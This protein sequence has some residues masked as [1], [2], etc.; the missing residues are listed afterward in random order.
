MRCPRLLVCCCLPPQPPSGLHGYVRFATW[1]VRWGWLP[2]PPRPLLLRAGCG[3]A[4]LLP[5]RRAPTTDPAGCWLV[6]YRAVAA[7]G[8]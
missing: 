7:Q 8:R 5:P 3:L 2:L 1:T 4:R 6:A